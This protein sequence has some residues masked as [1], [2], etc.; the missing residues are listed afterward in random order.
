MNKTLMYACR[1]C[2]HS[3]EATVHA[4]ERGEKWLVYRKDLMAETKCVACS[5]SLPERHVC[6]LTVSTCAERA[7]E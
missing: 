6:G 3:E 1:N 4:R 2:T 7:L 5:I